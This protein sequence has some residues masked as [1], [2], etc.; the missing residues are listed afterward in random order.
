[1]CTGNGDVKGREFPWAHL[2]PGGLLQ[3]APSVRVLRS[4][5]LIL[6]PLDGVGV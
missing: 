5:Q 1:M 2:L 3:V 6:G 4:L